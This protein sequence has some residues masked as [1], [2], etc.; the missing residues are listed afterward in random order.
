MF[1]EEAKVTEEGGPYA[2]LDRNEARKRI[3]ADLEEQGF[4]VEVEPHEIAVLVSDR[5]K[6]VI[7][8]LASGTMVRKPN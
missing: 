2:G 6:D 8:P 1:D 4:L 5:S 7:E 3:V